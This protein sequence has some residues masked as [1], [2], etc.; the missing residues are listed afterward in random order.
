LVIFLTESARQTFSA[1]K[2]SQKTHSFSPV[3]QILAPPIFE[4][5][6]DPISVLS[7]L[8]GLLKPKRIKTDIEK[9]RLTMNV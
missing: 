2:T 8:N 9:K 4:N 3:C 5:N 1:D 7:I 6:R